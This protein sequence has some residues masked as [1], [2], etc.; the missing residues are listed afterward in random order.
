[1]LKYKLKYG[2]REQ[3][4]NGTAKMTGGK[5]IKK[6]LKYN[7]IGKIISKK[8][9][10]SAKKSNNLIKSIYITKKNKSENVIIGGS[11]KRKRKINRNKNRNRNGYNQRKNHKRVINELAIQQIYIPKEFKNIKNKC[12][13]IKKYIKYKKI[14]DWK[15]NKNNNQQVSNRE[16]INNEKYNYKKYPIIVKKYIK[17]KGILRYKIIDGRHRLYK[18]I[19]DRQKFIN[20]IIQE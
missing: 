12:I 10:K 13:G 8:A 1:M 2:S 14:L 17:S 19:C 3:V 7:K 6:D 4:M 16:Y 9:S 5:L 11:S 15:Y 18:A 20:V